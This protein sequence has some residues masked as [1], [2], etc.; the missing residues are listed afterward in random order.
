MLKMCQIPNPP[1]LLRPLLD[2]VIL[3]MVTIGRGTGNCP[4][5]CLLAPTNLFVNF[6]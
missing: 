3:S 4:P 1:R 2:L 6:C 5:N